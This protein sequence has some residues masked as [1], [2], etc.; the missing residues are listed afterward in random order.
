L[1]EELGEEERKLFAAVRVHFPRQEGGT[2]PK[3]TFSINYSLYSW[4]CEGRTTFILLAVQL[5]LCTEIEAEFGTEIE[6]HLAQKS[7][8]VAAVINLYTVL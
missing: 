6:V 5:Q 3:V 7:R 2:N 8:W 4:V 1:R